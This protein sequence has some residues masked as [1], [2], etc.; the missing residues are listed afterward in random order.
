MSPSCVLRPEHEAFFLTEI[1]PLVQRRAWRAV[2]YLRCPQRRADVVQDAVLHAWDGYRR[3]VA[4]GREV[5][6]GCVARFAVL[7]AKSCLRLQGSGPKGS[8]PDRDAMSPKAQR[9]YGH[10]VALIGDGADALAAPGHDRQSSVPSAVAFK[11]DFERWLSGRTQFERA[12]I[13]E[14]AAGELPYHVAQHH[15]IHPSAVT[16]LRARWLTSW[17]RFTSR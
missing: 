7:R 4:Q 9:R 10:R 15:H 12:V 16:K 11:L 6:P 5:Q 17:R 8:N 3:L 14:L 1:L 13:A 2:W